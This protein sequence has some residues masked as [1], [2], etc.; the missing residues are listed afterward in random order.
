VFGC[1]NQRKSKKED[2]VLDILLAS[3]NR[4][5]ANLSPAYLLYANSFIHTA[6]LLIL[7]FILF[8]RTGG[9]SFSTKL[10]EVASLCQPTMSRYEIVRNSPGRLYHTLSIFDILN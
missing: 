4:E 6:Q 7:V 8:Y 5:N 10:P 3:V 1:E 2:D 9:F